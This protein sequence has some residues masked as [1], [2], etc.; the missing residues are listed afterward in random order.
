MVGGGEEG[1]NG[2]GRERVRDERVGSLV[3][4]LLGGWVYGRPRARE[5]EMIDMSEWMDG[6]VDY[7]TL[8]RVFFLSHPIYYFRTC[9]SPLTP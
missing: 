9:F 6:W 3:G 7:T 1:W 5:R 8:L 4:L 2:A